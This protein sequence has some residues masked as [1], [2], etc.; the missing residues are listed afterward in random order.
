MPARESCPARAGH[1]GEDHRALGGEEVDQA[2]LELGRRAAHQA[3]D[4]VGEHALV[5]VLDRV[6]PALD[7]GQPRG[8]IVEA[9][10]QPEQHEAEAVAELAGE[11]PVERAQVEGDERV[12]LVDLV[13]LV[14]EVAAMLLPGQR[15]RFL[16]GGQ[17]GA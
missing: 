4:A 16:L 14:A 9:D 11:R 17:D 12:H 10:G 7:L 2:R 5:A 6:H 13:A 3:E 15:F 8:R 1:V